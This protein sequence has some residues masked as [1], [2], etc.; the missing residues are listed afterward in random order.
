MPPGPPT[1]NVG[2]DQT[3]TPGQ[4][5]LAGQWPK[6]G[7]SAWEVSATARGLPA[8][9]LSCGIVDQL[10]ASDR[11]LPYGLIRTGTQRAR[12]TVQKPRD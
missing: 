3:V 10:A 7:L 12:H 2:P 11:E 8:A 9:S 6:S 1:A 4:I 5:R